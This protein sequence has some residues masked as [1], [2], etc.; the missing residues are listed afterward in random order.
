MIRPRLLPIALCAFAASVL[1]ACDSS[2][3]LTISSL[4]DWMPGKPKPEDKWKPATAIKDPAKIYAMNCL[5][6]HSIGATTGPSLALDNPIYLAV[7]PPETLTNIISNGV[8]GTSMPAFL[9][10]HGGSL[11]KEQ[12]K[13]LVAYILEKKKPVEGPVPP[14]SA[15]AGDPVAGQTAFATYL[16]SFPGMTGPGSITDPAFLG[17]VSDQ[18]LRS[19][20]IAGRPELGLPDYRSRVPGKAMSDQE[21]ADVVAW[22]IS[23]RR[24]EFGQPLTTTNP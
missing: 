9:E 10:S 17:L 5:G 7:L 13:L 15:P 14:Y 16:A 3:P 19:L 6:C 8:P 24:N 2:K 23:N 22:L 1:T 20:V 12:I 11:S 21:I 4:D 18:Y